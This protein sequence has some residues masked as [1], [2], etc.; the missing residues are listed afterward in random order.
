MFCPYIF[1]LSSLT[2]SGFNPGGTF[3][4]DP[5]SLRGPWWHQLWLANSVWSMIN[6]VAK[7]TK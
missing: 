2:P 6:R 1:I 5:E 4:P 3:D 7:W